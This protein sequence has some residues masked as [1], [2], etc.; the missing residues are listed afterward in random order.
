MPPATSLRS[1]RVTSAFQLGLDHPSQPGAGG[2]LGGFGA[3]GTKARRGVGLAGPIQRAPA[4]G[5]QLP[6]DRR[7]GA[8]E[9]EG[10][11][12]DGL[13][14]AM[15]REISSRSFSDS[16]ASD[17]SL[18]ARGRTPPVLAIRSRTA[19]CERPTALAMG[20]MHSPASYRSQI[21]ACSAALPLSTEVVRGSLETAT[22]WDSP[23]DSFYPPRASPGHS[24]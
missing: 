4:V 3:P 21:S 22:T 13:P 23:S 2:Q 16:R 12:A 1:V 19:P 9:A 24:C 5:L 8:V 11:V 17:H 6:R 14:A 20:R 15:P 7:R 18:S 10:D